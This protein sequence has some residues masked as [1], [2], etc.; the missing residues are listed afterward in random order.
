MKFSR[1]YLF[2]LLIVVILLVQACDENEELFEN[3]YPVYD[4]DLLNFEGITETDE[5]GRKIN[6]I[7]EDD[8]ADLYYDLRYGSSDIFYYPWF[9]CLLELKCEYSSGKVF[10]DWTTPSEEDFLFWN[11][12]RSDNDN[13]S[14]A[15]I[16]NEKHIPAKGNAFVP[17]DYYY[18]DENITTNESYY[19]F[20]ELV[21]IDSCSHLWGPI[22]LTIPSLSFGPAYPNPTEDQASIPI[23]LSEEIE[24]VMYVINETGDLLDVLVDDNLG[25]GLHNILW[26]AT[27]KEN[28]LYRV[29]FHCEN[30]T[31]HHYGDILIE[32]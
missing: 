13:P 24:I 15:E 32:R 30:D 16:I 27:D 20:L 8:W 23:L 28:G 21:E 17:T 4:D 14:S 5:T 26:N 29:I 31:L 3:N 25:S 7:D 18:I 10:I 19:Y 11:I 6:N 9:W 22:T 12:L 2:V 1:S